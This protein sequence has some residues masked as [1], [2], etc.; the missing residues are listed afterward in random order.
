[1]A[2]AGGVASALTIPELL[3]ILEVIRHLKCHVWVAGQVLKSSSQRRR[4]QRILDRGARWLLDVKLFESRVQ[5]ACR[6]SA[7]AS[8]SLALFWAQ[9]D[10]PFDTTY[11]Q[12]AMLRLFFCIKECKSSYTMLLDI[13]L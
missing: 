6:D 13:L 12:A 10:A 8:A 11:I 2:Y 7:G 1:V 5:L 4:L 9:P 3:L